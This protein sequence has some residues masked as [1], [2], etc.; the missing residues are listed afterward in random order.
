MESPIV[1][2]TTDWGYRDFFAGM[3]KSRLYSYIPH[4]RVVDITHGI[5]PYQLSNAIFVAKQACPNFPKGTIHIIDVKSSQTLKNPFL[6]VKHDGQFYICTDNGLPHALFGED[7]E[8]MV[9]I[10]GIPQESSFFTFAAYD[11]FCKVAAMIAGGATLSDIGIPVESLTHY[12]PFANTRHGDDMQTYIAY[13]DTYGN[14]NL[15]LTYE[16]FE[17][18]RCGR[19]FEVQVHELNLKKICTSYTDVESSGNRRAALLLTVSA[20]GLL[21]IAIREGSAEQLLGLKTF[22]N[23]TIR[24]FNK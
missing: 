14:A 13:I 7:Y 2:L 8:H 1:T 21:Q 17:R 16:E 23:I 24:F 19:P 22:E 10:D 20:T 12:I 5:E 4:V 15:N 3:V 11:L 9:I 18:E 6:V